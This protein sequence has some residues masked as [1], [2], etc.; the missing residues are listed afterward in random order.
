MRDTWQRRIRDIAEDATS[1]ATDLL[2]RALMLL[3]DAAA[4]S[5]ESLATLADALCTAQPSMAGLRNAARLVKSSTDPESDLERLT[6]QVSRAPQLIARHAA[7]LLLL[8][9][10]ES[11]RNRPLRLVTCSASAAVTTTVRYLSSRTTIHV[12]CAESRPGLEGRAMAVTLATEGLFVEIFTDAGIAAALAGADALIV[13]ADAV[14]PSAFINKIGT[15][16]LCAVAATTGVPA[17]VLAGREKLLDGRTFDELTLKE[18]EP[19]EVYDGPSA[20]PH[21][22][23]PYFERVPL[24]LI[25]TLL[26]DSG[27]IHQI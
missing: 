24:E 17:Y 5:P 1:G 23:N 27:P 10:D 11:G 20:G 25:S 9:R 13:G 2:T 6:Q 12:S 18:G 14:G 21:A 22:R 4:E 26:T 19:G 3:R 16:A 7:A 8:R 15:R